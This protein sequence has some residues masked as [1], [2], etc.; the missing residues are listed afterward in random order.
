MKRLL[1]WLVLSSACLLL[2]SFNGESFITLVNHPAGGGM[3]PPWTGCTVYHNFEGTPSVEDDFLTYSTIAVD[4]AGD[5]NFKV[6]STDYVTVDTETYLAG[7]Q[8]YKLS[9][10][11]STVFDTRAI[12]TVDVDTTNCDFAIGAC[13]DAA[14]T[15]DF[16]ISFMYYDGE[17]LEE[18]A[19]HVEG[20]SGTN[21]FLTY[22]G[23][24]EASA[25]VSF[26]DDT[27]YVFE[28][29]ASSDAGYIAL[30]INGNAIATVDSGL[31]FSSAQL[32]CS[33]STQGS[34]DVWI[35]QLANFSYDLSPSGG[36]YGSGYYAE[37]K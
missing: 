20:N 27:W 31:N 13:F 4:S 15:T 12:F 28:L 25:T 22:G 17:V 24:L 18:T 9:T 35:D 5:G 26:S 16:K 33:I 7:T 6:N 30:L 2:L 10:P 23:N 34:S 29:V 19:I 1:T 37:G 14:S 36:F 11:G 8:A 21:V 3:T 32:L